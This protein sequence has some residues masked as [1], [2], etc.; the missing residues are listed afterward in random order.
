MKAPAYLFSLSEHPDTINIPSLS[1]KFF[2][3]DIIF[4]KYDY[5]ILTSKQAVEALQQYNSELYSHKKALCISKKTAEAFREIGG[6]TLEV[7]NGYGT[8]LSDSIINYPKE[9]KWLYLRATIVASNFSEITRQKGYSIEEKIVYESSCS[10]E[11]QNC[12]VET[13]ATLIFTSPSS[14]ECF[15]K[16]HKILPSNHVVVIGRTTAKALPLG[17]LYKIAKENTIDSCVQTYLASY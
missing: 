6:T 17:T 10:Q 5:L 9:T 12:L 8:N 2:Q 13:D 15:L 11:I 7:A 4:E 3:P 16:H 14:V 1:I